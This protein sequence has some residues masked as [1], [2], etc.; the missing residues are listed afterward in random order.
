MTG[1]ELKYQLAD[2]DA[3]IL[4]THPETAHIALDAAAEAG[5]P[6]E[7]VYLFTEPGVNLSKYSKHGLRA[8]TDIWCSPEE[9]KSWTWRKVTRLEEAM[10]KT[11]VL[12][13][14]SGYVRYLCLLNHAE[15]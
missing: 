8:W 15:P 3:K 1:T 6:R 11:A 13:Y 7:S 5:M 10:S 9:V 4:L 2:S 12:N 14:S